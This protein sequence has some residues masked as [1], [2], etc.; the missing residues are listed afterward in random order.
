MFITLCII[1]YSNSWQL[2]FFLSQGEL[3]A[4]KIIARGQDL[5]SALCNQRHECCQR[6]TWDWVQ[7][8]WWGCGLSERPYPLYRGCSATPSSWWGGIWCGPPRPISQHPSKHPF[9]DPQLSPVILIENGGSIKLHALLVVCDPAS[10]WSGLGVWTW[11]LCFTNATLPEVGRVASLPPRRPGRHPAVPKLPAPG[12]VC[13]PPRLLACLLGVQEDQPG[14]EGQAGQ[15][16]LQE[17]HCRWKWD[18]L[19]ADQSSH[20]EL[21]QR[22]CGKAASRPCHVWTGNE[23]ADLMFP[24]RAVVVGLRRPVEEVMDFSLVVFCPALNVLGQPSYGS[25]MYHC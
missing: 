24:I 13:R 20:E 2:F 23:N 9:P 15:G 1:L 18:C 17:V 5:I 22:L 4:S 11:G 7:G 12:R 10:P 14:E 6:I 3:F 8:R 16:H 21:H 19:Q 25:E